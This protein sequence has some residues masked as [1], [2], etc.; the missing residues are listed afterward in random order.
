MEKSLGETGVGGLGISVGKAL[1]VVCKGAWGNTR[2][3][4][5][6]EPGKTQD[7]WSGNV[8]GENTR[9]LVCK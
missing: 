7:D 9:G 3:L 5:V 6:N 2:G 8:P 4:S 1:E